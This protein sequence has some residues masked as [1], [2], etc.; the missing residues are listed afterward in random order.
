MKDSSLVP[1]VLLNFF[2]RQEEDSTEEVDSDETKESRIRGVMKA[3]VLTEDAD[4]IM[5]EIFF[6]MNDFEQMQ[7]EGFT[8]EEKELFIRLNEKRQGNITRALR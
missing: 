6:V 4:K 7:F 8:E 3:Y 1:E 2:N 5:D